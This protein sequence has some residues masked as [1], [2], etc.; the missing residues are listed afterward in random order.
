M[1]EIA[2][3]ELLMPS[4]DQPSSHGM[5]EE[6][7]KLHRWLEWNGG[8]KAAEQRE[9]DKWAKSP[10]YNK[11]LQVPSYQPWEAPGLEDEERQRI[12][13]ELKLNK[14]YEHNGG[15]SPAA[16]AVVQSTDSA[17]FF[18]NVKCGFLGH[19]EHL[20]TE[21][22]RW[23]KEISPSSN[24]THFDV[25]FDYDIGRINCYTE[26]GMVVHVRETSDPAAVTR[27]QKL[28]IVL[29]NLMTGELDQYYGTSHDDEHRT[30]GLTA[31]LNETIV[32]KPRRL[33]AVVGQQDI[34]VNNPF[35]VKYR[36]E[37]KYLHEQRQPKIRYQQNESSFKPEG[38]VGFEKLHP[39][40][41]LD[42]ERHLL[43]QLALQGGQ[44]LN[45]RGAIEYAHARLSI[46]N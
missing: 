32:L 33:S 41:Q 3:G 45:E 1:S 44:Y 17:K 37:V 16:H 19:S 14:F 35:A 15:F 9:R 39:I 10:G 18:D 20:S 24:D 4:E 42:E 29:A 6:E 12:Y 13:A 46:A 30:Q 21:Q 5:T 26:N 23:F 22:R 2:V 31:S 27:E 8:V 36:N 34:D 38:Y 28:F 40:A 7:F 11:S 25:Q 43:G